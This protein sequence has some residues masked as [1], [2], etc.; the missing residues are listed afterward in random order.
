MFVYRFK[1]TRHCIGQ[2]ETFSFFTG[3]EI[4][5]VFKHDPSFEENEEKYKAIKKELLDEDS[6]ASGSDA[7][8][9]SQTLTFSFIHH[10]L[11]PLF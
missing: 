5:N 11:C 4:L 7:D 6:D 3:E 8:S 1:K 2:I 10:K 9:G